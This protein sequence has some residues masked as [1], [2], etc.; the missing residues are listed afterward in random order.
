M[1]R[2]R[3]QV[4]EAEWLEKLESAAEEVAM[5]PKARSCAIDLFLSAVPDHERSKPAAIAACLYAGGLIAGEEQSQVAIADAVGVSRLVIQQR[6]KSLLDRAGFE[7][8]TW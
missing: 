5:G 2:A 6:W 1:Y 7:P 3:D 8:P 4:A